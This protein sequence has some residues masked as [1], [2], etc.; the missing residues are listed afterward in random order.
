[1]A[2]ADVVLD[3]SV[4][5]SVLRDEPRS[6]AV[7]GLRGERPVI[8]PVIVLAELQ[9]L[10]SQGRIRSTAAKDAQAAARLEPLTA[11]DALAGGKLHGQLRGAGKSKVSLGDALVLA[12]ARR[13]GAELV[14]FDADLGS[15]PDVRVLRPRG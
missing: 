2:S 12:T 6:E 1:M 7:E 4:W 13:L 15:E 5:V 10:C 9:S 8:L 11:E 3:T 14:T